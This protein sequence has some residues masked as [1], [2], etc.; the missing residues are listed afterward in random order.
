MDIKKQWSY[1]NYTKW[2]TNFPECDPNNN[3][4]QSPINI[5]RN[6]I[7]LDC[8][9]RCQLQIKY[10]SSKCY[11][12]NQNNTITIRYEPGSFI[13]FQNTWYEL[14]KAEIHLPSA[15]TVDNNHFDMEIDLYHCL[16]KTCSEGIVLAICLNAGSEYGNSANFFSQF[17][18]QAP[19]E[20]TSV[21]REVEVSPEWNLI[22][23]F[24]EDLTFYFYDG[25]E[26]HPPCSQGWKWIVFD[27][28]SNIGTTIY[29]TLKY[30]I[31]EKRG[32]NI[33]PIQP[34]KTREITKVLGKYVKILRTTSY[35]KLLAKKKEEEALT[36]EQIETHE[37]MMKER[38]SQ[39]LGNNIRT[40]MWKN[41]YE[42]NKKR[43]KGVF[44]FIVVI[45]YFILAVQITRFII[46]NDLVN[47][48]FGV[49]NNPETKTNNNL[50]I[51]NL[52]NSNLPKTF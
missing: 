33:R 8:G 45:S 9:L 37:K 2:K 42:K 7:N 27:Q 40:S 13:M 14:I 19:V 31:I 39:S 38:N 29:K 46:R 47:R 32:E 22:D 3:P 35:K 43:I 24:P 28:P 25:S 21:E 41:W 48:A 17:V 34:L 23:V 16:D 26:A 5:N 30:N 52:S 18:N 11:L 4:N 1:L 49:G 6:D 51:N 20:N 36:Q 12:V 50:P 10:Q 44:I 15:H